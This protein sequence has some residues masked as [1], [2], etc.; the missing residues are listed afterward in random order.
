MISHENQPFEVLTRGGFMQT[1]MHYYGTL[2]LAL[3]AG[4]NSEVAH[5]IAT[6]AEFVDDS[7]TLNIVFTDGSFFRGEATGHHSLNRKN[8]D[9]FDQRKVWIPFHFLP[10]NEG[11]NLEERLI[12]LPDS[13]IAQEMIQWALKKANEDFGPSMLGI[14][15]HVY[16]DTFAH[17]GFS[18]IKSKFNQVNFETVSYECSNQEIESYINEKSTTFFQK[19]INSVEDTVE[20]EIANQVMLGHGGVATLPDRPFLKWSFKYSDGRE[21]G[22]RNNPESFLKAC[23]KLYELFVNYANI[24]PDLA[25]EQSIPFEKINDK[26]E[27]IIRLEASMDGRIQAWLNALKS[28]DFLARQVTII[29]YDEDVFSNECKY[30][31]AGPLEFKDAQGSNVF[32]FLRSANHYRNYVLEELLPKY[33]IN[34]FVT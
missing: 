10:G 31:T 5:E 16:T 27:Q 4:L 6:A 8:L 7:D 18:G 3:A 13:Q 25:D 14:A 20:G 24:R 29:E 2:A 22:E 1:D 11:T 9:Q 28:G 15:A 30:L 17:Y 26:I 12:C 34:V 19:L 23:K 21:S 32:K 33:G